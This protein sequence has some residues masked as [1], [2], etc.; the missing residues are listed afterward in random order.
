MFDQLKRLNN[1]KI[2]KE[3]LKEEIETR[4]ETLG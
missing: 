1:D 3:E 4:K 2:N